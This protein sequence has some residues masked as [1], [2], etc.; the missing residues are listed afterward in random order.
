MNFTARRFIATVFTVA[1]ISGF[2]M[3]SSLRAQTAR[4]HDAPA[5]ASAMKNPDAGNQQAAEAGAKL[6]AANC[7]ACHTPTGKGTGNIPRS[8]AAPRNR[9]TTANSSG[10]SPMA[11]PIAACPPGS[12]FPKSSAGS[13]S[14]SSSPM[15]GPLPQP[16]ITPMPPPRR[17]IAAPPRTRLYRFP[18]TRS[19]ATFVKL[20]SR[21]CPRPFATES[22][23]TIAPVVDRPHDAWPKALP[24]F[25][26]DLYATNLNGPR[27][28]SHRAQWRL[29]RC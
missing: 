16:P 22:S 15:T 6:Y 1:G 24:G 14:L 18:L 29:F 20:R 8:P 11:S 4:F 2:L 25:K 13:S 26:V 7:A 17:K 23:L 27:T 28:D 12:S 21:I 5:S 19:P 10:S 9:P 3:F